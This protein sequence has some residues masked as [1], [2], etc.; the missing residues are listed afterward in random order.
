MSPPS[1]SQMS[2]LPHVFATSDSPW[3]PQ[4]L[5]NEYHADEFYDAMQHDPEVL[6]RL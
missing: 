6:T 4:I 3:N 2:T 5:N 1:A